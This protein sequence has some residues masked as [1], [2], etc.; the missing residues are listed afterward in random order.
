MRTTHLDLYIYDKFD[1]KTIYIQ[2][3]SQYNP[4]LPVI[5]PI[6]AIT[7]PDYA[8][9]YAIGY[10]PGTFMP[11]TSNAFQWTSSDSYGGLMNLPDG[12][13]HIQQSVKPNGK[14]NKSFKYFRITSLKKQILDCVAKLLDNTCTD[15]ISV[16]N[17]TKDYFIYLQLLDSAKYMVEECCLHNEGKIIY[18]QVQKEFNQKCKDC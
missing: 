4:D 12:L 3:V 6:L 10:V 17:N 1:L 5:D 14:I 9:T 11:I 13:W 18:N 2:D 16:D 15:P 7:P 8:T